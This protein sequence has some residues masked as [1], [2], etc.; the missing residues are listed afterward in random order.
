MGPPLFFEEVSSYKFLRVAANLGSALLDRQVMIDAVQTVARQH[1]D[2]LVG[3]GQA[4][5]TADQQ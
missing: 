3:Q 4:L 2:I 5:Q 1:S